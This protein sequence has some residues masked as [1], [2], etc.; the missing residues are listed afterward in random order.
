M[1]K[2][3][4]GKQSTENKCIIKTKIDNKL[5]AKLNCMLIEMIDSCLPFSDLN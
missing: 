5:Y 4:D 1:N 2:S 3:Y